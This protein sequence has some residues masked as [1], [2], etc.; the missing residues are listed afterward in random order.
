MLQACL[1]WMHW[2]RPWGLEVNGGCSLIPLAMTL[3]PG[4]SDMGTKCPFFHC[5][6]VFCRLLQATVVLSA[7]GWLCLVCLCALGWEW[8]AGGLC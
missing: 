3:V 1:L 4:V 7:G 2:A 6:A 5:S 8:G